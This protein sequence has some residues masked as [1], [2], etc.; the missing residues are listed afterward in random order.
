MATVHNASTDFKLTLTEEERVQLL[1]WLQE[2]L[3]DKLVEEH[4]TDAIDYR[5]FVLQQETILER[6]IEK[7]K[8]R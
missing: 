5:Q 7:F 4:R 8:R 1:N 3:R 2:R 6:L